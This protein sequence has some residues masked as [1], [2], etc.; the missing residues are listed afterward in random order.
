MRNV[1]WQRDLLVQLPH[2]GV[3]Q[4][5]PYPSG[6]SP[7]REVHAL[8]RTLVVEGGKPIHAVDRTS[9][10]PSVDASDNGLCVELA[11]DREN[12]DATFGQALGEGGADAAVVDHDHD[13]GSRCELHARGRAGLEEVAGW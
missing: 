11:V 1:P 2:G 3:Q 4:L 5:D 13:A 10:Q 9:A 12:L 6:L 7:R 8:D